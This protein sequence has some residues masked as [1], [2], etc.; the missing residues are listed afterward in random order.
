MKEISTDGNVQ[1]IA[2]LLPKSF[3]IFYAVAPDIMRLLLNPVLD[4]ALTW[5]ADFGFHDLGKHYPN[6]TGETVA[7]EEALIVDQTAVMHWMV[8]AYQKASGDTE[9]AKPYIG[10]LQ[11]FADYLVD[12]GLYVSN[13]SSS[14]DSIGPT[15]NQTVLAMY[16]AIALTS[17]GA[18]TGMDNYTA[19]GKHFADII[20]QQGVNGSHITANFGDPA[21]SWIS[22][23]PMGFDMMLGLNTFNATTYKMQSDWYATLTST[24]GIPFFSGVD[25]AVGDLIP[26]C[27]VTSTEEVRDALIGGIHAFLTDG[28]NNSPGPTRWYVTGSNP[29]PG[30]WPEQS[31]I[32]KPTAGAYWILV[33]ANL[34]Q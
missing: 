30:T 3:P 25:Y 11:K 6:A 13:Q 33:G 7:A 9:Y 4:Y 16:S 29:A 26:W 19:V 22:T 17:F 18:T 23:Y 14:V 32:D 20:L 5:P 24:Y 34:Y 10:V 2:D 15:P 21:S 31:S 1:T 12:N 28:M 8:Y 27:A